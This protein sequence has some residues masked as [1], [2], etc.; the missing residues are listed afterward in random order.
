MTH[1]ALYADALAPPTSAAPMREMLLQL[2]RQRPGDRF[3]FFL[4]RGSENSAWWRSFRQRI[5]PSARFEEAVLPW[6]RRRYNL[7]T[8]AGARYHPRVCVD[9]DVHLRLDVGA[10]GS[11]GAPLINVVTDTSSLKGARYSSMRWEGRRLF[12]RLFKEGS[13]IADRIVCISEATAR[14]VADCLPEVADKIRI[15]H[16]GIADEWFEPSQLAPLPDPVSRPYF[17]WYGFIAPRKNIPRLLMGYAQALNAAP[18]AFPDLLL[19]GTGIEERA[20]EKEIAALGLEDRVG[21]MTPQPLDALIKLVSGASGLAFP[22]L[23]EGF[24]VPIVE[25]FARGVPVLTSNVTSMPEVAGGLAQLCDPAD[26]ASIAEGLI[27]MAQPENL[28]PE[29]VLE[30][31]AYAAGFTSQRAAACYGSLIGEVVSGR[32]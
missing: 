10:M 6:S 32:A 2:L 25:A 31:K 15:I 20:T 8:L 23:H 1:I 18:G 4:C 16:N 29:R 26:P 28:Q 14:D 5:E 12:K 17:I 11:K 24:G 22:S 13:R 30:R 9:A 7:R 27:A 3:T 21:R 19:I